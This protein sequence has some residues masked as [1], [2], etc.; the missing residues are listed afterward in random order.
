MSR[1]ARCDF[2]TDP[3]AEEPE[4]DQLAVHAFES[5]HPLCVVC[6]RRSL[7]DF[8]PLTCEKCLTDTQQN[9]ADVVTGYALL[10]GEIGHPKPTV[11]DRD[12]GRTDD[13]AALPGGNALVMLA[14]GSEGRSDDD[15]TTKDT[16]PV[17]VPHF[18]ATWEDDW[19]E[20]RHEPA[21]VV[22]N[23]AGAF[24]G[25]TVVQAAGYLERHMRWAANTHPAFDDFARELRQVLGRVQDAAHLRN[26]DERAAADCFECGGTLRRVWTDRGRSDDY[27][28][29]QCRR[30]YDSER[31]YLAVRARL[32]AS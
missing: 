20:T 5:Q 7:T 1:C 9:L 27:Q 19:R 2:R 11:Y 24:V 18:L 3:E 25:R 28:C 22:R 4:R 29:A 23:G 31:Y 21:A 6:Q 12:G 8:E 30:T 13:G 14:G 16:D 26:H 17:S 10:E 32:E 15:E